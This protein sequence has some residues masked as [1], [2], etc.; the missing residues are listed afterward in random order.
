MTSRDAGYQAAAVR[1]AKAV[2][3]QL[4]SVDPQ[5]AQDI[6]E[7]YPRAGDTHFTEGGKRYI[8]WESNTQ[9][10][11]AAR[12]ILE[13]RIPGEGKETVT[14]DT[15]WITTKWQVITTPDTRYIRVVYHHPE[16]A[17][18]LDPLPLPPFTMPPVTRHDEPDGSVSEG[19]IETRYGLPQG[20]DWLPV[21][22]AT[23]APIPFSRALV[24][25]DVTPEQE[26]PLQPV[27]PAAPETEEASISER[28]DA[29]QPVEPL[30]PV[31]VTP[32]QPDPEPALAPEKEWAK[33]KRKL[34]VPPPHET[35][36]SIE[37]GDTVTAPHFKGEG[38]VIHVYSEESG[39]GG[40]MLI[41][42]TAKGGI[43]AIPVP[44]GYVK[45][46]SKGT[47]L[48]DAG[49]WMV[50]RV[51]RERVS[52][53]AALFPADQVAGKEVKPEVLETAAR[54]NAEYD[55]ELVEIVTG[56]RKRGAK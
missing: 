49:R 53:L 25:L 1:R 12:T 51:A 30:Q 40:L 47:A 28:P 6:R 48:R 50:D 19:H 14:P 42:A 7:R 17:Q 37:V 2:L 55:R 34:F 22:L 21:Y 46:V 52:P 38:T 26:P 8:P 32:Q 41:R 27:D 29:G 45:L 23:K 24:I 43:K 20:G 10:Y 18:H 33:G 54:I 35:K 11:L 44:K 9:A 3:A 5:A 16:P 56:K 4:E 15:D 39:Q 36:I 31:T 13:T